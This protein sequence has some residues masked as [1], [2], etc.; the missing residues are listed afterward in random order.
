MERRARVLVVMKTSGGKSLCFIVLVAS[1]IDGVTIVIVLITA[2]RANIIDRYNKTKI[3]YIVWDSKR[4]LYLAR[5]ILVTLE[6]A[7]SKAFS[8][9]LNK[10]M[11]IKQLDR[12]IIDEC[13][14]VLELTKN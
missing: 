7:I 11:L 1:V 3:E 8:R 10:K 13:H 6:L 14:I 4:P 2:L 9:F 12:I 5:I